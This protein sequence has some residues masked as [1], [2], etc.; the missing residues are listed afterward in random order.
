[1]AM[2]E[3]VPM[4]RARLEMKVYILEGHP[5]RFVV[6]SSTREGV[7]YLVDPMTGRCGCLGN[8]VHGHCKHVDLVRELLE[9]E[10]VVTV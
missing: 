3:V 5:G 9:R 2:K 6:T 7:A 4:R 8:R 1:M 10:R